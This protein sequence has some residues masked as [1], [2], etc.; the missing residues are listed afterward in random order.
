MLWEMSEELG[1]PVVPISAVKAE[2]ISELVD[3]AS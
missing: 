1:I 3:K 2:G